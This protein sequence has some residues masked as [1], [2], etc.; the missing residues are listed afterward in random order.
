MK[1]EYATEKDASE[2][3]QLQKDAFA[4]VGELYNDFS[5]APL[6]ETE[7]EYRCYFATTSFLVVRKNGEIVGSVAVREENRTGF[8]GRLIV[9]PHLHGK[10]IGSFLLDSVETKFSHLSRL[11]LFTGDR[12]SQNLKIYTHKGYREFRREPVDNQVEMIFMEKLIEREN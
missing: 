5:I 7:E 4:L 12:C 1:I 10:G 3:L 2:I 8:V 6:V 11:E 9:K